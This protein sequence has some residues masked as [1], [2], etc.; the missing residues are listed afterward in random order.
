MT[1]A[2]YSFVWCEQNIK[3]LLTLFILKMK[4]TTHFEILESRYEY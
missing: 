4:Y 3:I 1:H 2:S